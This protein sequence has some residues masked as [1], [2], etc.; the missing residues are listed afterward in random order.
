[1]RKGMVATVSHGEKYVCQIQI[2]DVDVNQAAGV[3]VKKQL[4]P[5]AGDKIE[6]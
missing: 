3:I 6:F 2:E 1:V 5:V 4:D